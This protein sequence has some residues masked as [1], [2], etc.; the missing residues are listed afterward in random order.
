MR[1]NTYNMQTFRLEETEIE[2][3]GFFVYLGSAVSES[4]GKEEDAAS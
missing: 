2:E 4:G 3:V 1:V